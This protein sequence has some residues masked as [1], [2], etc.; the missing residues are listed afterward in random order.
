M[1]ASI[2]S[3][4]IAIHTRIHILYIYNAGVYTPIRY[5]NVRI[6]SKLSLTACI[7]I[8]IHIYSLFYLLI[9]TFRY[10]YIYINIFPQYSVT[11]FGRC[12]GNKMPSPASKKASSS[13]E[14]VTEEDSQ[15]GEESEERDAS[16]EP[17]ERVD[18]KTKE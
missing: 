7:Y 1:A 10:I 13:E 15:E 18:F 9:F 4:T 6:S 16:K 2:P 8:Y 5:E 14:D 17:T 11:L 3:L 12:M